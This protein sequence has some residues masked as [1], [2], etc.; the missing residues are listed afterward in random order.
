M[1]KRRVCKTVKLILGD[2]YQVGWSVNKMSTC[3]FIK[4]TSKGYNFLD[5]ET[6]KCILKHHLYASKY[7]NNKNGNLFIINE[8][9]KITNE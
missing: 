5:I 9:L 2:N 1:K 6:N 3:K 8:L 4:V 7:E